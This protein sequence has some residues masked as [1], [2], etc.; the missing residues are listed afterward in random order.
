MRLSYDEACRLS[1]DI[2]VRHGFDAAGARQITEVLVEAH[3]WGRPTSGLNHLAHVVAAAGERRP[4]AVVRE[5]RSSV[6]LDGGNNPGFL[7]A[8]RAMLMAVAKARETGLAAAAARNAYL[9]G[10]NGYYAAMAARQD[11]IGLVSISSGKRVAPAG[12]IDPVFGTNPIAIAVPTLDEPI[13]LDMAT[14]S[15]NVGSLHRA[16]RLKEPIAPGLAIGP[17]GAP[18]TDPAAALAGAILPF[19]GHKGSGLA[20]IVQ[21]L[22]ILAGGAVVP[23]GI[24][25][26]GYF[27]LALDPSM[28]MPIA[29]Y[30]ARTS[31]L[32]GMMRAVRPAAGGE[33]VRVPG[34]RSFRQRERRHAEGIDLDEALYRELLAL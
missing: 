24:R 15:T 2:L 1:D 11:M 33:T 34:E 27:V 20:M 10:I 21:C 18:T 14:A 32:V 28:F 4:V 26:F 16:E 5:D 25:D 19:G 22:G 29:E 7:V 12:G 3:L 17:D 31:E 8:S 13:V 30:K 6:L 23:A 9:G